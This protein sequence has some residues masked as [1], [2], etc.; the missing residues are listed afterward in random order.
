MNGIKPVRNRFQTLLGVLA[1]QNTRE[2]GGLDLSCLHI[3]SQGTRESLKISSNS[4]IWNFFSR[5]DMI[6]FMFSGFSEFRSEP[7]E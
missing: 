1:V 3:R 6:F 4:R 7:N 2:K 5:Q